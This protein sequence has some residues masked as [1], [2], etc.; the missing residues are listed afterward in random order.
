MCTVIYQ[1][2]GSSVLIASNRDEQT[3]RLP[4]IEPAVHLAGGRRLLFPR[5][6]KAG[7]SWIAAHENGGVAV[8]FNGAFVK[9]APAGSYRASRGLVFL[10]LIHDGF[11]QDNFSRYDLQRIEPFSI[12]FFQHGQLYES[13]WDGR[14]KHSRQ[15]DPA[16]SYL[17]ASATLYTAARQAEKRQV[18]D[19]WK[20]LNPEPAAAG[21]LRFLATQQLLNERD[22]VKTVSSTC[23]A[24]S[25]ASAT[26]LYRD[27][28]AE[29]EVSAVIHFTQQL[30]TGL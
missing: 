16:R 20:K 28:G 14:E 8:L 25:A 29:R 26:M 7:G 13:R 21:L 12:V 5:D 30:T 19:N 18:F 15:L 3:N 23:I 11:F 9:H 17:W 27:A 24:V 22:P 10:D 2:A 6:A 4:A 1:P